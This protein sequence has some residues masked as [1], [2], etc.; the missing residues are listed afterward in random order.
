MKGSSDCHVKDDVMAGTGGVTTVWQSAENPVYTKGVATTRSGKRS[1][2]KHMVPKSESSRVELNHAA[3]IRH[4]GTC[5]QVFVMEQQRPPLKRQ[6]E[7]LWVHMGEDG[8][9]CASVKGHPASS[10]NHQTNLSWNN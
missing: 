4:N 2:E 9:Q 10:K 1:R 8:N 6:V 5:D 3:E 7:C